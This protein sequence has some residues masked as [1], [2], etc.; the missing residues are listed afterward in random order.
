MITY[1]VKTYITT[2]IV[3]NGFPIGKFVQ[4]R[5]DTYE[6]PQ[7]EGTK[8]GDRI[9]F[10]KKKYLATLMMLFN[11]TQDCIAKTI[12]VSYGLLRKWNT[13]AEF[14][15]IVEAHCRE[16][17]KTLNDTASNDVQYYSKL[18][19]QCITKNQG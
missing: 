10:S 15:K 7:R 4:N 1:Q 17:A 2:T 6:E 14:K 3:A 5:L 9:G 11:T 19:R 18:L 13:E 8:K 12:G 16:F